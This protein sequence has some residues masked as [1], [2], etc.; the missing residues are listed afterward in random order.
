MR[1]EFSVIEE[2]VR[3]PDFDHR[4]LADAVEELGGED[5]KIPSYYGSDPTSLINYLRSPPYII[6]NLFSGN[7]GSHVADCLAK[8]IAEQRKSKGAIDGYLSSPEEV[9]GHD[10]SV[11]T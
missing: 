1:D 5:V 10:E 8:W 11:F 6:P 4:I 7:Y 9:E 3:N 2:I